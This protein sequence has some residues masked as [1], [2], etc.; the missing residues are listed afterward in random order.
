MPCMPLYAVTR[1]DILC[2]AICFLLRR[3][4]RLSYFAAIYFNINYW[5]SLMRFRHASFEMRLMPPAV[6]RLFRATLLLRFLFIAYIIRAISLSLIRC[7]IFRAYFVIFILHVYIPLFSFYLRHFIYFLAFYYYF[8]FA[9]FDFR[10]WCRFH[11]PRVYCCAFVSLLFRL[12]ISYFRFSRLFFF[13]TPFRLRALLFDAAELLI[14]FMLMMLFVIDADW[15]LTLFLWRVIL[16]PITLIAARRQPW[17]RRRFWASCSW[18]LR[19]AICL[20]CRRVSLIRLF[21]PDFSLILMLWWDIFWCHYAAL[22]FFFDITLI[23]CRFIFWQTLPPFLFIYASL[24]FRC[25]DVDFMRCR[26]LIYMP[27]FFADVFRYAESLI[28]L[29]SLFSVSMPFFRLHAWCATP[30]ADAFICRVLSRLLIFIIIFWLLRQVFLLPFC[31]YVL[32]YCLPFMIR[33]LIFH[34]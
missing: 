28:F 17:Y 21:T 19:H 1:Y 26:R 24:Y 4:C 25:F 31:R 32:F 2:A 15:R 12:F 3:R 8:F 11:T 29:F 13:I 6:I 7:F 23:S 16:F 14:L 30:F 5:S 34:Y 10:R 33:C 18:C 20:S 9:I 27:L 22:V